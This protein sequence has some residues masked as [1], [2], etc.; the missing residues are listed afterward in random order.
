MVKYLL[1]GRHKK[2]IIDNL[3]DSMVYI[4]NNNLFYINDKRVLQHYNFLTK[5][6]EILFCD[7][8]LNSLRLDEDGLWAV[9][10]ENNLCLLDY[11]KK[12]VS[13]SLILKQKT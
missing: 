1:Y 13:M 12:I 11:K 7:I 9:D 5:K 10:S 6:R 3:M 4:E 8:M 2:K